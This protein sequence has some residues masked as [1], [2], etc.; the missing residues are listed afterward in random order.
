MYMQAYREVETKMVSETIF[1]QFIYKMLPTCNHLFVF[2][3]QFCAQL[4][5]SG[6]PSVFSAPCL[7]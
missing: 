1:S 4:A 3:K 7:K 5:L 6:M 2:K